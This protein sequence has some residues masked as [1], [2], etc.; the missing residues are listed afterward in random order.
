MKKILSILVICFLC[1]SLTTPAFAKK[2]IKENKFDSII[3]SNNIGNTATIAISIKN[4][5][6]GKVIYE[7][8]QDKLLHPASTLKLFSTTAAID[9]LGT[10]YCF[11]TQLFLDSQNNV[12]IKL[13]A[14]PLLTSSDLK[15]LI[16]NLKN[17]NHKVVNNVYIDDSII[18]NVEW[19][20][21]WM[22]DDDTYPN[23]AKFSAYNIDENI[24]NINLP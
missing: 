2:L 10:D 14:D 3:K 8:D 21:G 20:T 13:G 17:Q 9:A 18:D 11:R 4:A 6:T 12:Y 19:G 15:Y 23:M 22:W 5:K 24:I 7:T 16:R 1:V